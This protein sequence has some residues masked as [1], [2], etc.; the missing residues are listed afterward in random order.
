M[1]AMF[2]LRQYKH[3]A[4]HFAEADP[5]ERLELL[6]VSGSVSTAIFVA[7]LIFYLTENVFIFSS[8]LVVSAIDFGVSQ[9]IPGRLSD[10]DEDQTDQ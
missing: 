1:N 4:T 10:D 7:P 2:E 8:V 6:L 9:Y 5:E 3:T